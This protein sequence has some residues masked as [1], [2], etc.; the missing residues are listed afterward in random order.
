MLGT[1]FTAPYSAVWPGPSKGDYTLV[2]RATDNKGN[3]ASSPVVSITVTNSPNSVKKARGKAGSLV[4]QTSSIE[5]AGAADPINT[6]NAVLASGIAGLTTDIEKAY[7]EFKAEIGSFGGNAATIDVQIKAAA[8]FSKATNGL[9]MR[10]AN[11]PNIKANLLRIAA[12]L[13]IAEDLMRSGKISPATFVEANDTKTRIDLVIGKLGDG[14]TAFS[15][16]APSSLGSIV[17]NGNQQPMTT[18]TMLA[19]IVPNGALPYELGGLSV[20]VGGVAVP[21][22]YVS[23]GTIKFYVPADVKVAMTEVVV[24]SQDGY[25]CQ[26][27]LS[28]EKNVS[29]IMTAGDEVNGAAIIA[30]GQTFTTTNLKVDSPEN[31]GSDKRTRLSLFATGISGS[32]SNSDITND[33]KLGGGVVRPNFAESITVE[34]LLSNGRVY[35]LPVEFAGPQGLLPGLDQINVRLIPELKNAGIVQ[36][37]LVIGGRRSNTP[38]VIIK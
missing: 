9:A 20:T 36:L 32:V 13:A 14:V 7:L 15:S 35:T 25:I 30:N 4:Q 27:L 10:S 1:D 34:A 29:R 33:I 8:L 37:T 12:H 16:M 2:A 31:V 21:V 28:V 17:G 18:L 3:T 19:P 23:P 26:G 11:S 6:E 24:S 38:T 22:L 5:Y